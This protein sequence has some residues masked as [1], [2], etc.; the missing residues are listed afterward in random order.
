MTT[1]HVARLATIAVMCAAGSAVT[2]VLLTA[3]AQA[4]TARAREAVALHRAALWRQTA[5][6]D[7]VTGIA[8]RAAWEAELARAD[9]PPAPPPCS[10]STSTGSGTSTGC[11]VIRAATGPSTTSR[12]C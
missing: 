5:L 1:R 2:T 11:W 10:S 12:V 8:S 9:T 4:R 6:V 7:D 3:R